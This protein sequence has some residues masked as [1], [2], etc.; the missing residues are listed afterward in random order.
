MQ[1][2]AERDMEVEENRGSLATVEDLPH[3][4]SV[5]VSLALASA[6]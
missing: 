3:E 1:V 6:H 2:N 5:E 4:S